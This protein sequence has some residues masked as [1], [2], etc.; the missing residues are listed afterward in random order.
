[1]ASEL[2]VLSKFYDRRL[3]EEM[4]WPA[5]WI[6]AAKRVTPEMFLRKQLAKQLEC[7]PDEVPA[8]DVDAADSLSNQLRWMYKETMG[9][10]ARRA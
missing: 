6:P 8:E 7:D 10:D 2:N 3:V 9:A 5:P 1:M 4:V